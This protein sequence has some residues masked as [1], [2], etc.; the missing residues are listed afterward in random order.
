[1]VKDSRKQ[2]GKYQ[3]LLSAIRANCV[4]QLWA[5]LH[6]DYI[7]FTGNRNELNTAAIIGGNSG[8]NCYGSHE[9]GS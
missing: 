9:E 8:G 2:P 5:N 4:S 3:S 7:V 6:Y 1:M